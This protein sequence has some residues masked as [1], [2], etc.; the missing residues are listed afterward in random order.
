MSLKMPKFK[1]ESEEADWWYANRKKVERELRNAKPVT[2]ANGKPMTPAEIAAAHVATQKQTQAISIRLSV[3][4]IE[5]A[6]QQ[7]EA[8]GIGYQTLIRMLL[9]ASLR[10]SGIKASALRPRGR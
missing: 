4:D 2:G 9:H 5:L 3:A 6:K 8:R 1:S 7:A 10:E